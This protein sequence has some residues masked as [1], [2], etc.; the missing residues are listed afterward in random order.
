MVQELLLRGSR[1]FAS[2]D[3]YDAFLRKLL[4]RRNAARRTR[5]NDELGVMHALSA[6]RLEDYTRLHIRVS[7]NSTA[8]VRGNF[9]SVPSQLIGERVEVR[10]HAEHLEVRYGGQEVQHMPRL[11]GSGKRRINYRHVIDSLVRKPGAFAQYRYRND[12]F[13]RVVFRVAYDLLQDYYPASADKQY[14]RLLE[15]AARACVPLSRFSQGVA[16]LVREQIGDPALMA[17]LALAAYRLARA[18][19]CVT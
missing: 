17:A 11:R 14:V 10:L 15:L 6:R 9:Y 19:G 16:A 7:R 12:L 3:E 1:D 18:C 4:K 5:L 8:L 13:P 2:R